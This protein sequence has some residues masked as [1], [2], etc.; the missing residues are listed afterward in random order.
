MASHPAW[1]SLRLGVSAAPSA[2]PGV[3]QLSALQEEDLGP[4]LVLKR[5]HVLRAL[6]KFACV[7]TQVLLPDNLTFDLT[8]KEMASDNTFFICFGFFESRR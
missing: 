5:L 1:G 4:R 6:K 2:G 7:Y 8:S 3:S